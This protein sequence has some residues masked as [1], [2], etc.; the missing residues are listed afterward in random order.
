VLV[1]VVIG[2]KTKVYGAKDMLKKI[3]L[4]TTLI[5]LSA[6]F[7][8][9]SSSKSEEKVDIKNPNNPTNPNTEKPQ[10]VLP[11]TNF[12]NWKDQMW[13]EWLVTDKK[14]NS[15]KCR[16]LQ[17][18]SSNAPGYDNLVIQSTK[19][20]QAKKCVPYDPNI[21]TII[22]FDSNTFKITSAVACIDFSTNKCTDITKDI[23]DFNFVVNS[24]K[25]SFS[26]I[27]TDIKWKD[28]NLSLMKNISNQVFYLNKPESPFHA[29]AIQW[30]N[31]NEKTSLLNLSQL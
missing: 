13:V 6:S 23:K 30:E 21:L 19:L 26:G 29:F 5:V 3:A 9:C 20:N 16:R 22:Y 4:Y 8:G 18:S 27:P 17:F 25:D 11:I 28:K 24:I 31:Q 7:L 12:A 15:Q 14:N 1:S 10:A 2:T